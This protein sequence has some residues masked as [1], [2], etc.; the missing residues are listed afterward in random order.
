MKKKTILV[1][2]SF[3]VVLM[4]LLVFASEAPANVTIVKYCTDAT[5]PGEPINFSVVITNSYPDQDIVVTECTDNPPAVIDNVFPLTI[6]S[7]TSVTIKGRY[8]PATNP[9]T[10]IVTCTGY[11]TATGSDSLVTKSSNPA[12]C[13]YPTGEGCTRTPGYWKNHP[14]AWPVEEIIIGGV[15][16]SKEAAIAMM[17]TPLRED[18]RYTMFNALAAAKLNALSGTDF[19]CVSTVINNADS[20][21]AAYGGSSVPGSS[22]PWK[23]GEPLYLILD[24][25]N[26]GFL[27]TPHCD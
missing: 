18:K 7:N 10:D 23:I 20:W 12:T 4:L 26:N 15:T 6:P 16:Y 21:M 14:E 25:Y 24:N 5:G 3:L 22:E 27:C 9:S 8:V 1:A 13:S 2:A 11:G 19:S 17:M